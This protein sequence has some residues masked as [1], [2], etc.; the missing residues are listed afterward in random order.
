M[1]HYRDTFFIL[2]LVIIFVKLGGYAQANRVVTD[3]LNLRVETNIEKYQ[4]RPAQLITPGVLLAAG[5]TGIYAFQDSKSH[6]QDIVSDGSHHT[7]VDEYLQF[8]PAAG[9]ISLGFI[10]NVKHYNDF[11]NRFVT[12]TTAYLFSTCITYGLKYTFQE[13]RPD[14]SDRHSFPSGHA[15]RAFTGAELMRIEYGNLIGLSGYACAFAVGI[16]R[17]SNDKHW[18]ND[19]LGGAAIGI[20]SARLAYW[21]LPFEQRLFGWN[22]NKSIPKDYNLVVC[23]LGTSKGASLSFVLIF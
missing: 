11:K 23:P 5:I 4:F 22:S 13:R 15:T 12:A 19:I 8:V 3:S 16:L 2:C 6:F 10:P 17:M 9:Y 14:F 21:L 7:Q 18:V 20:L 1:L